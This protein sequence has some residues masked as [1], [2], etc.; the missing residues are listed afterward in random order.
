MKSYKVTLKGLSPILMHQDN[1]VFTES[2]KRWRINP[3]N[4]GK[5]VNGDDQQPGWAWIGYLYHNSHVVGIPS[6]N[7]MTM[8]REGGAKVDTGKAKTTF[9]RQTQSGLYIEETIWP[10]LLDT[11]KPVDFAAIRDTLGGEEDFSAH[12]PAVQSMGFDLMIK[13]AKVGMSKH[14]RVRPIFA[15]GWSCSGKIVVTDDT[16]TKKVLESILHMAGNYCGLGDWRPSSPFAPG[17]YGMFE[18][19]VVAG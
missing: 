1:P 13:R 5:S 8:L 4:K 10:L 12:V 6:D 16:L 15:A 9:K 17:R 2:V 14:L 7:L 3:E 18:A 11:G 19:E